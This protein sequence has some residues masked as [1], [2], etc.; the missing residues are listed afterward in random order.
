MRVRFFFREVNQAKQAV[1][2]TAPEGILIGRLRLHKKTAN[3]ENGKLRLFSPAWETDV[4]LPNGQQAAGFGKSP[5]NAEAR[6]FPTR[7]N[8]I[9]KD[10]LAI[11]S[12]LLGKHVTDGKRKKTDFF[13]L[14]RSILGNFFS[15]LFFATFKY[16][17]EAAEGGSRQLNPF[18]CSAGRA[19]PV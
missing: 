12:W 1:K 8:Q 3:Q 14:L 5:R 2:I 19:S 9:R 15:S 6:F 17:L 13:F 10:L 7:E 4:P 18:T 11:S 16:C